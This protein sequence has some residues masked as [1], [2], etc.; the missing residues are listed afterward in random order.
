MANLLARGSKLASSAISAT[1][2]AGLV[3]LWFLVSWRGWIPPLY[4]PP[5]W[6]VAEAA[7][8]VQP[9][10]FVQALYTT[11]LIVTGLTSGTV[12]G[13]AVGLL[14]RQ[15]FVARSILTRLIESSRPVPV[16]ALIPFFI[17]WFGFSWLGKFVLVSLGTFLIVVVGVTEAIDHLD[18]VFL[19]VAVSFGATN[20]QFLFRGALPA[21][22]PPLLA[23]L[24]IALAA[25]ATLAVVSE[26]MGATV[27]LGHVINNALSTFASHTVFL[28]ALLLGAIGGLLD[29]LLRRLHRTAVRWAKLANEAV[30][31]DIG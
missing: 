3:G 27:G 11:T 8:D 12:L 20:G 29:W 25:A 24:R 1:V 26:Y 6:R 15:S 22:M 2:I 14:V 16:V 23:P 7:F 19:R 31:R 18:P 10:V 30:V 28:C 21:I 9:N 4:L 13:I 17:L 5:P